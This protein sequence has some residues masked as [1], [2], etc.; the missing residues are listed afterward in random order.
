MATREAT[1]VMNGVDV[2]QLMETVEA[3]Q[4]NPDLA[5]FSFQAHTEWMEGA[6]SRTEI[7]EFYGVGREDASREEPFVLFGD[8]PP[9]LLGANS[10]P[11][12]V[13]T[14]LHGL[15]SCLAVGIAYNAA[16]RG[17]EIGH[18]EFDLEGDL[19]LRA[20][21]GLSDEVR[22]GFED[23]RVNYRISTDA[24]REEIEQL[25]E[26]VQKTSPVLDIVANSVPVSIRLEH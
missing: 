12:A 24:S 23:I 25:C 4:E 19:D 8:E 5:R 2:D 6:R 7:K 15:A 21:L 16:A 3:L 10:A 14:V 13:E 18:M 26:Y 11:N 22:P 1:K 9:V 17:I 20:F